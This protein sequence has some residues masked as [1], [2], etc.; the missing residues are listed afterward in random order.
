MGCSLRIV[1]GNDTGIVQI[2]IRFTSMLLKVL[3]DIHE[4]LMSKLFRKC[5]SFLFVKK[6]KNEAMIVIY[7]MGGERDRKLR[8]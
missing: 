8:K 7:G 4:S 6:L 3:Y 5:V 2:S 1:T